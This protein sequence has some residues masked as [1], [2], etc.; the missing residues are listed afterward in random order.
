MRLQWLIQQTLGGLKRVDGAAAR[1]LQGGYGKAGPVGPR[2]TCRLGLT[3]E[4]LTDLLCGKAPV[5]ICKGALDAQTCSHAVSRLQAVADAEKAGSDHASS[6]SSSSS[7][8]FSEWRLGADPEAPSSDYAKLGYSKTDVLIQEGV[9]MSAQQG[10]T[11]RYLEGAAETCRILRNDVFAP[12][13]F[14]LDDIQDEI[15]SLPGFLCRLEECPSTR[16]HFLPCVVRRMT[17]GGRKREGNVHMDSVVP[18][19][20]LSVNVYL[21]VPEDGTGGE[22][23]L[24]PIRKGSLDRWLNSHFFST[25][26]VQNFY[27]DKTFYTEQLLASGQIEPIIYRPEAGDVVFIDPAYPHAVRDFDGPPSLQRISLQTFSQVSMNK[28]SERESTRLLEYAV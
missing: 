17:P 23:I 14:P 11:Q 22:L 25:V 18:G 8:R 16:R 9:R 3:P 20:T 6:E 24:Y 1:V 13:T 21:S 10:G 12:G 15:S 28:S 4:A 2:S 27:P 7:V 26:E 19:R 5:V